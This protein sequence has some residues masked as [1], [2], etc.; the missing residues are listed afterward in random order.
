MKK[1]RITACLLAAI[2]LLSGCQGSNQK[3]PN[4]ANDVTDNTEYRVADLTPANDYY[5]YINAETLMS[6]ELGPGKNY[7]GVTIDMLNNPTNRWM[8]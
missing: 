8:Q 7:A 1:G 5:G 4:N 3:V 6:L 2:L